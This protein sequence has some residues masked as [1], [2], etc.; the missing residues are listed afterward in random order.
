MLDGPHYTRPRVFENHEVPNVLLSG[1]HKEIE[2]W[3]LKKREEKTKKR[4]KDLWKK[5]MLKNR[6]GA[7]DE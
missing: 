4:R 7:K 2:E 6:N 1:N 3:F 5:Y